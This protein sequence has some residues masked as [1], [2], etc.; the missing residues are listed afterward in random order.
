MDIYNL[1]EKLKHTTQ[2]KQIL[3]ILS[4][5]T[6]HVQPYCVWVYLEWNFTGDWDEIG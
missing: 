2:A 5:L 1:L 4:Q 3:S 6:F